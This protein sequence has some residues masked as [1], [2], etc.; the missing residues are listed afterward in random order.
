[1]ILS[2][3]QDAETRFADVFNRMPGLTA[4]V[5]DSSEFPGFTGELD[6]AGYVVKPWVSPQAMRAQLEAQVRPAVEA[7]MAGSPQA[8]IDATIEAAL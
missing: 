1:M 2:A 7:Q 8:V 5:E 6:E 4:V 3:M